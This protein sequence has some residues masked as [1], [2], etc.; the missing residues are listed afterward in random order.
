MLGTSRRWL[1]ASPRARSNFYPRCNGAEMPGIW[2]GCV[3]HVRS[4]FT[5][6]KGSTSMRY[7]QLIMGPAG[8]GK[9]GE[10]IYW[11]YGQQTM[12]ANIA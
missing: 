9:V 8:S 6:L 5:T 11:T 2:I 4:P 12:H 10:L 1:M 7:A 3:L